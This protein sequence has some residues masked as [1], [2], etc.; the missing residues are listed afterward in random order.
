VWREL[1]DELSGAGFELVTVALETRG[2]PEAAKW[3]D[4]AAAG[5]PSLLDAEHRLA[6]LYGIVNVPTAFWVDESGT[7]VRPPETAFPRRSPLLDTEIPDSVN[8]RLREVLKESRKLSADGRPYVAALRDWVAKGAASRYALQPEEV[9]T[10]MQRRSP[11]ACLAAAHF[12]LA[13]HLEH[14]G[15]SARAVEHFKEAH[16][17]APANWAQKRQAWSLAD[18]TQSPN[19]TYPT[20]WLEEVRL[21]GAENYYPN[22]EL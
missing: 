7:M 8:P 14:A 15:E 9:V 5:H 17:L 3:I 18:R 21:S 20:G 4:Q 11:E 12:E 13:V 16:R 22:P 10:R 1:R 2:W 19:E 6:G